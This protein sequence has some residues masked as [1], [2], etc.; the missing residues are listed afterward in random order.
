MDIMGN[1]CLTRCSLASIVSVR[2]ACVIQGKENSNTSSSQAK[3]YKTAIKIAGNWSTDTKAVST[4]STGKLFLQFQSPYVVKELHK[5]YRNII[6][7][8]IIKCN[9]GSTCPRVL[10]KRQEEENWIHSRWVIT[11]ERLLAGLSWE[12]ESPGVLWNEWLAWGLFNW[13]L[14]SG[15]SFLKTDEEHSTFSQTVIAR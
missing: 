8:P 12:G 13:L 9:G 14:W 7:P 11:T 1:M 6:I 10:R 2:S 3:M 15:W 4:F 5:N